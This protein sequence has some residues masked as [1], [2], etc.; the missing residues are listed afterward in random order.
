MAA[1]GLHRFVSAQAPV[2]EQ[3]LAELRR[4]R[5]ESHWMWF[6]FP[7]LVG[8]GRSPTARF[9][10]IEGRDEAAAY[11]DHPLLGA[12]LLECTAAAATH[13]ER[14]AERIFG[15]VDAMKFR[16]SMTL[17]EAAAEEPSAFA[18]ALDLFYGGERDGETLRLL[19]Y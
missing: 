14:G 4:G 6:V 8:L 5:K 18:G 17:F 16:S 12:R 13:S 19:A 1:T 3:A 7:Q 2:Y 10:G 11:L 15:P 9:Y